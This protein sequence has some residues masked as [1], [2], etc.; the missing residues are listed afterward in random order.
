[1]FK[2]VKINGARINVPETFVIDIDG[3]TPYTA[4]CL[5]FIAYGG[6]SNQPYE[7]G[8]FKFIPLETIPKNSGIKKLRGFIVN[9]DMIF[10][11]EIAGGT[12]NVGLGD[13]IAACKNSDGD[14]DSVDSLHGSDAKLISKDSALIDR[15]VLVALE[16]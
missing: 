6:I 4:G 16:W 7:E 14:M 15:K 10:E 3:T 13:I 8:S 12:L 1:M 2:L 11:T 9:S 5:Y